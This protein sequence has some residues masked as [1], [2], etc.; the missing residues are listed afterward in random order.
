MD[1]LGR[2]RPDQ[3]LAATAVSECVVVRQLNKRMGPNPLNFMNLGNNP[4]GG[5]GSILRRN[6]NRRRT[7]LAFER[8]SA[9]RLDRDSVVVGRIQEIK[10]GHR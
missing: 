3:A 9:L 7:E 6:P 8:T 2:Q 5:F 1:I 4:I 10:A